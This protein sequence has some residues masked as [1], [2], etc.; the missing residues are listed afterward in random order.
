MNPDRQ[1][2]AICELL[3]DYFQFELRPLVGL[4]LACIPEFPLHPFRGAF[5]DMDGIAQA[6]VILIASSIVVPAA[7]ATELTTPPDARIAMLVVLPR[8]PPPVTFSS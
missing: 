8:C 7:D 5:T 6:Q 4:D 1:R 2:R 3:A